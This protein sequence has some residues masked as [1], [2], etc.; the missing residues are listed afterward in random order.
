VI[1]IDGK[2]KRVDR[3]EDDVYEVL[4]KPNSD[5]PV[6]V[7]RRLDGQG[8]KR[9][10]HRNLL[11]PLGA[12][13]QESEPLKDQNTKRKPRTRRQRRNNANLSTSSET[14]I[15]GD[16]SSNEEILVVPPMTR[17]S[18]SE[19][20]QVGTQEEPPP[21]ADADTQDAEDL[22]EEQ[23]LDVQTDAE[24][25]V[26]EDE[27]A[28]ESEEPRPTPRP[29]PRQRS[30]PAWMRSGDFVLSQQPTVVHQ[31]PHGATNSA[32]QSLT[33]ASSEDW[34]HKLS[35][36]MKTLEQLE[37]KPEWMMKAIFKAFM[38]ETVK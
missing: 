29:A 23:V 27:E 2:H 34:F 38:E 15:S 31:L 7:V 12:R 33:P 18:E 9:T 32:Q 10:L 8:L 4:E 16:S 13:L 21:V 22:Q 30:T 25:S 5:M 19:E 11:L 28:E 20:E 1:A 14:D 24:S 37:D 26:D 17:S 3:W 35:Q 36:L 6:Y